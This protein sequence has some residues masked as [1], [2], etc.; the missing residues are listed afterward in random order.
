MG[1]HSAKLARCKTPVYLTRFTVTR[2]TLTR[3]MLTR[4]TLTRIMLTRFTLTRIM[5][6]RF[7]SPASPR[8]LPQPADEANIG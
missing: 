2:F 4:F 5:L 8:P 1:S 3:F 6:T 7:T